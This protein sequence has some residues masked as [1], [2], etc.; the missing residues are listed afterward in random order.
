[1]V[2]DACSTGK[3]VYLIDIPTKSK[4]FKLFINNLINLKLVKFFN[5]SV[6]L[7]KNK[8]TLNDTENVANN[9][10]IK[11]LKFLNDQKI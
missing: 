2:S 3:P 9:I 1:M 8:N 11:I 10:N 6:S 7:K 5:G 4:K